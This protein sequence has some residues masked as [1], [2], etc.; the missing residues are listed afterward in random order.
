MIDGAGNVGIGTTTPNWKLSV[1]GIGSFDDYVHLLQFLRDLF[2]KEVDLGEE[3]FL[4]EELKQSILG[5]EKIEA[6]L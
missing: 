4:R 2:D 5:G 3:R 6:K 1:A